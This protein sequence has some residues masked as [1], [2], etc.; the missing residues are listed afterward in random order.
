M[1][2]APEAALLCVIASGSREW[3][4][5]EA[6]RELVTRRRDKPE[7]VEVRLRGKPDSVVVRVQENRQARS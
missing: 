3:E 1:E 2:G 6:R 7:W 5:I 4:A